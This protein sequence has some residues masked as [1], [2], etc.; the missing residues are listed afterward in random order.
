MQSQNNIRGVVFDVYKSA[1]VKSGHAALLNANNHMSLQ[2]L[3]STKPHLNEA[4]SIVSNLIA[5]DIPLRYLW[6][7]FVAFKNRETQTDSDA[8]EHAL[9]SILDSGIGNENVR[10]R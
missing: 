10:R 8:L 9:L 3:A 2:E 5:Q 6:A 1:G 7:A 4:C